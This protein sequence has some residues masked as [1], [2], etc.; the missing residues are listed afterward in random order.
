MTKK[1]LENDTSQE[2]VDEIAKQR[3]DL[4]RP[5]ETDYVSQVAYTR[6]LE[7]FCDA[8]LAQRTWVGLTDG[9]IAETYNQKDWDIRFN[10]DYERAIEAKLKEKN[11]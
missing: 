9:D 8:L 5:I 3:H 2:R 1:G 4:N 10:F 7:R 11:T 6:A